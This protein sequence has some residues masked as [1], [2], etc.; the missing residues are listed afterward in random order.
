M[1]PLAPKKVVKILEKLG[2]VK[3]RQKGSHMIF[4]HPDCRTTVLPFHKEEEI[5]RGLLRKIIKDTRTT[6]EDFMK[7]AED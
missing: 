2:F 5:G 1:K 6:K 7:M 3:L 4:H